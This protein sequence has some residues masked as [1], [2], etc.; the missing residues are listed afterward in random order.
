MMTE[1]QKQ[2]HIE[3][4]HKWIEIMHRYIENHPQDISAP[5][6]LGLYQIALAA[7]TQPASPALKLPDEM[8]MPI[9]QHHQW[10][11]RAMA[12]K[13]VDSWNACIAETK[14]L[15]APHT[16]PIEPICATGGAEWVKVSEE[17]PEKSGIY[18]CFFGNEKCSAIQQRVMTFS[19]HHKEFNDYGV[20]H[21]MPRPAAPEA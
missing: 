17:L 12:Q 7:L 13:E 16:A 1:E 6:T 8:V 14:R 11:D 4:A 18:W 19:A 5:I 21:W 10:A 2:T 3:A 20:T 15:N 9:F